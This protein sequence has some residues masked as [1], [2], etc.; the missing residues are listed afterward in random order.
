L[1]LAAFFISACGTQIE[2][3][4]WPGLTANGDV[5][6]I[7]YGAGVM[8]IDVVEEEQLWSY[9]PEVNA[10]LQFF[11]EPSVED[12]RV[13][14]GDYGASGGLL[15]PNVTVSIYS[16][17][18]SDGDIDTNWVQSELA[19]DRIIAAP[20]HQ[21]GLVFVGTADNFILALDEET[22]N[23]VWQFEAQHSIW[24]APTYEDGV[25]YFGSLDKHVYALDA[26]TGDLIWQQLVAGSVS[27]RVA[28]G[29][30]LI[31]VGSFDKQLHALD[32]ETG[33][34]RWE[35]PQEGTEDWIWASP[36]L[37]GDVV[38]YADKSGNLYAVG[39][40]DGNA[41]W[42][43]DIDSQVVASPIVSNGLVFVASAGHVD[44]G[45]DVRSGAII[46][47]DAETGDEVWRE[48]TITPLYSTPVVIQDWIVIAQ[49]PG[50]EDLLIVYNQEDGDEVWRYSLPVEE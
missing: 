31:Y 24:S 32:K 38:Y 1:V 20:I 19:K 50:A 12:G 17:D 6:Y 41:I 15:S 13:I 25:L 2:G 18:E 36:V 28:V 27:G 47:L 9:P 16:L 44:N 3:S 37:E 14:V 40:E 23:L 34:I 43:A 8:A 10:S 11:A 21:E 45:D 49:A 4:S 22:G 7:A 46:A 29:E 48:V 35:V 33:E 30:S 42:D 39:A 26:Q 5:V